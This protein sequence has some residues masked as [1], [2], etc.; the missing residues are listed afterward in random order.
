MVV[1]LTVDMGARDLFRRV[2]FLLSVWDCSVSREHALLLA[3]T[4]LLKGPQI[5]TDSLWHLKY[6]LREIFALFSWKSWITCCV[7]RGRGLALETWNP[8]TCLHPVDVDLFNWFW[9]FCH[10]EHSNFN[11]Q[12][13]PS[14]WT[15]EAHRP[16]CSKCSLC[17]SVSW[18]GRKGGVPIQSWMGVPHPVF[19]RGIPSSLGQGGTQ[20]S[21][22]QG[23]PGL[24][25]ISWMGYHQPGPGM[26]YLHLDLGWGTPISWMGN[27][28]CLDLGWG[29]PH[30]D[31]G[32]GTPLMEL[33]WGYPLSAGPL[34][35]YPPPGPGMGYRP[36]NQMGYL[37]QW[38][39]DRYSRV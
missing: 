30:L 23:V 16:P 31:L 33:G 25:P 32:W 15:Q 13:S 37:H 29:T 1:K 11:K 3:A 35:G 12:E 22:G 14:T 24:P 6:R 21:L 2:Q 38:W 39:T 19:D 20:S 5:W 17:W 27:T 10:I 36:I 34:M 4:A 7:Q 9:F 28:P 26:G 8:M 18:W